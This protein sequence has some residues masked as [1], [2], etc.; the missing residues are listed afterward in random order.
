VKDRSEL[1]QIGAVVPVH[2][3]RRL[4][5][6]FSDFRDPLTLASELEQLARRYD[7]ES[8]QLR[9]LRR[10]EQAED[11]RASAAACRQWAADLRAGNG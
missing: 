5:P 4:L 8:R 1:V 11:A 3:E 7:V 9:R 2:A 10:L 6:T